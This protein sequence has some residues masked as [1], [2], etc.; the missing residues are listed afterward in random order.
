MKITV[1][2]LCTVLAFCSCAAPVGGEPGPVSPSPSPSPSP[3]VIANSGFLSAITD[4]DGNLYIAGSVQGIAKIAIDDAHILRGTETRTFFVLAAFDNTHSVKWTAQGEGSMD[5]LFTAVAANASGVYAAGML[6]GTGTADFGNGVSVS[7]SANSMVHALL[8]K[9]DNDGKAQWATLAEGDGVNAEY[10]SIALDSTGNVYL[11]G[12]ARSRNIAG[13]SSILSFGGAVSIEAKS[14]TSNL[15]V[16]KFDSSGSAL[17]A[18]TQSE[19]GEKPNQLF[20]AYSV[21]ADGSGV[22][23]AAGIDATV[24]VDLGNGVSINLGSG[25]GSFY[26][27]AALI[28]YDSAGTAQWARTAYSEGGASSSVYRSV[29]VSGSGIYVGGSFYGAQNLSLDEDLEIV[30]DTTKSNIVSPVLAKYDAAGAVQ[31]ARTTTGGAQNGFT[32]FAALA[33]RE[34][35]IY[36]AGI[37]PAAA[38][39]QFGNNVSATMGPARS[40]LLVVYDGDGLA[41]SAKTV[42]GMEQNADSDYKTVAVDQ[43]SASPRIYA[44]GSFGE[45]PVTVDGGNLLIGG[46]NGTRNALLSEY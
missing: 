15:I 35:M 37:A 4:D 19:N 8:V 36:A 40:A 1:G 14:K 39:L 11:G 44:A 17:W 20:R 2:L 12:S 34:G 38:T 23:V 32:E 7:S 33:E 29:V 45:S 25:V 30:P 13:S 24:P 46:E 43:E 26:G 5:S 6:L 22:Y 10:A 27:N 16:A 18:K 21:A 41:A 42:S 28:K 3:P 9:Y 31:W